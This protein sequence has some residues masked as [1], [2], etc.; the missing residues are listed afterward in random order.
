MDQLVEARPVALRRGSRLPLSPHAGEG[1]LTGGSNI[2]ERLWLHDFRSYADAEVELSAGFTVLRGDNG[3]GKTNLIEA[4]GALAHLGSFRGAPTDAMVR[5]GASCAVVRSLGR[6]DG[7]EILIEARFPV[8]GSPTALVNRQRVNRRRDLSEALTVTVFS[9][10]DL[11]IVQAGPA[12]RRDFVD[13]LLCDLHPRNDSVLTEF[14]K[15]LRQRNALLKQ[16]GGRLDADA[17]ITLDVW[18]QRLASVGDRLGSLRAKAVELLIPLVDDAYRIVAGTRAR[19]S[20]SVR[21]HSAWWPDAL[22]GRLAAARDDDVRRGVSTV[23]PH[24]DDLEM[25]IEGLPARTHASQGE[26]RSLVLALR[27]AAHRLV[28]EARGVAPVL[29]LDDVFSELDEHR[30]RALVDALPPGQRLVTTATTLPEGMSPDAELVVHSFP[31][32]GDNGTRALSV[33]DH[34]VVDG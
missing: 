8:T 26:Q 27:L 17:A 12:L 18:D 16:L 6:Y 34:R 29:L 32:P 28:T 14:H 21:I 24:R 11:E 4:I 15:V 2:I 5:H 10:V 31:Q 23:G 13:R 7:R 33:L 20:V 22:E 19:E 1:L 25:R 30:A 9:P 3:H